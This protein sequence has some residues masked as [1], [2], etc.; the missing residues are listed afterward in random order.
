MDFARQFIGKDGSSGIKVTLTD[1]NYNNRYNFNLVSLTKLL[2][3]GWCAMK[4]D[5]TGI[6]IGNKNGDEIKFDIVNPTVC[7]AIFAC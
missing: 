5:K 7:R 4:G 2:R 6:T 3:K 1:V